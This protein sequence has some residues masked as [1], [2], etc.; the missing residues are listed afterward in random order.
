MRLSVFQGS[1]LISDEAFTRLFPSEDGFRMF[2]VD[3][4]QGR[5]EE[6]AL[7]FNTSLS[8][9]GFDAIPAIDRLRGFYAV[10][11][12]YLAM[13]LVL[14]GLG[15]VL[16]SAALGIVVLR[17]LFERRREIALLRAVGFRQGA[18]FRLFLSEYGLLLVMGIV[19]GGVAA[20]VAM[21]PAATSSASTVS[22]GLQAVIV[23]L[24]AGIGVVCIGLALAAGL[25]RKN[26]DALR[27][28]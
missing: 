25:G 26:M 24:I 14:G 13:F 5:V 9:F 1:I 6:A 7:K 16:G 15:L 19:V 8:R 10:E 3:T 23:A 22:F 2:L 11:S 21:V 12:T 28:E 17:N 20:S 4:P 27:D 18:L